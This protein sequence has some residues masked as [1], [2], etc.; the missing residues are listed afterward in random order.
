MIRFYQLLP[1][2]LLVTASLLILL[3]FMALGFYAYPS[4]DDFCMASGVRREGLMAHLWGHYFA[5]SGRYSGNTLYAI[6]PLLFGLFEG[7]RYLPILLILSLFSA[8]AY[9]LSR[10]FRMK[11]HSSP[12]LIASLCFVCIYLLGLRHTASS[13]YWMAGS[14]SYQTAHILVLITLGLIIRLID[15]QKIGGNYTS[16]FI[17]LLIVILLGMGTNETNM[18]TLSAILGLAVVIHLRSGWVILKPW[19][20]LLVIG[21]LCFAVVYFSPGNAI[22][23]STFPLR[24]DWLRSLNGSLEMGWWTLLAWTG[25]PLFVVATLLTPFAV[26]K[27]YRCSPRSFDIP[28]MLLVSLVMITLS[29]PFVLQ[30]PAWWSMGGWP[31]PRT[32][33]AIFFV[34]LLSWF[35]MVGTL[36]IRLLPKGLLISKSSQF[37]HKTTSMFLLVV[38]CFILA[39]M[40][41]GKF[42]QA[43]TDLWQRTEPFAVY[44]QNRHARIYDVLDRQESY[45]TVPAFGQPYPRS[46]YFNGIRSDFR[47]WR[48]VCYAEYFGLQGIARERQSKKKQY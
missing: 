8:M 16:V 6:Y 17:T 24:H 10:L 41:N 44:M 31:P 33:D 3:T 7:Y 9:F 1:I 48:N 13:L 15:R 47:D 46:I 39:V 2:Y 43:Q 4:A 14:L 22:R 32:I 19:F 35:L 5:W 25:N 20:W 38:I 42:Q 23:E 11:L 18:I 29:I 26:A 27:L 34:F 21:L 30:F 40:I 12:I 36:S 37:S 28:W 45:L